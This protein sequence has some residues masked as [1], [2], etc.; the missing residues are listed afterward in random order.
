M[1]SF[2]SSCP[3]CRIVTKE[4]WFASKV[5]DAFSARS[6]KSRAKRVCMQYGENGCRD[7]TLV[8]IPFSRDKILVVVSP[9]NRLAGRKEVSLEDLNGQPVICRDAGSATNFVVASAFQKQG[10]TPSAI[11][12]AANTEFIKDMVKKDKGYS[13]LA[14]ICV[15]DEIEC[16]DLSVVHLKGGGFALDIDVVHAKGKILSPAAAT[17]LNFLLQSNDMEDLSRT[18]DKIGRRGKALLP[19]R[20]AATSR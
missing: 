15:R 12:E 9:R 5:A 2:A 17:F 7:T 20:V 16:G 4:G 6:V 10:L 3:D 18:A 19:M 11:V 8:D 14:S 1:L 13:F